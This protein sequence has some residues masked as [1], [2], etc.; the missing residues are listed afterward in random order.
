MEPKPQEAKYETVA[1]EDQEEAGS[2]TEVDESLMGD[3]KQWHAQEFGQRRRSKRQTCMAAFRSWRWIIDTALLLVILI[4][5]LIIRGERS[6]TTPKWQVGGDFTGV[7]PKCQF[8]SWGFCGS[9][10]LTHHS[11]DARREMGGRHGFRSE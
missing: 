4:L 1:M 7:G 5:L 9:A 2:S 3:D 8:F 10:A 11:R 6:Q